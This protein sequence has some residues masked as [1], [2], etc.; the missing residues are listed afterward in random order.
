VQINYSFFRRITL[1]FLI[2]LSIN[3]QII[4]EKEQIPIIDRIKIQDQASPHGVPRVGLVLSGGGARGLA[5]VGVFKAL[6][7]H[8]IP[9]NLIVGTSMGSLVG[10]FYAA[11]YNARELEDIVKSIDWYNIFRDDTERENLFLGQKLEKDRFLAKIRFDNWQA[12]LP[13]SFTSGQKALSIISEKLYGAKY[14][15]IYDF[16]SLRVPFRVVATDLISGERVIISKGDLAEAIN[17]SATVPLLF[18][19]VVWGDMLLVDG[20]LRSNLSVDVA[21][22][23]GMDVIIV[24]DITSPLRKKNELNAPWEVADQVTTI[25]M[26]NQYEKQ[27]ILADIVVKPDLEDVGGTDFDKIDIMISA[28]EAAVDSVVDQI[29]AALRKKRSPLDTI[30]INY[31]DFSLV[32]SDHDGITVPLKLNAGKTDFITMSQIE[33]DVELLLQKGNYRRVSVLYDDSVLTY[34]AEKVEQISNIIIQGNSLFPD[35]ILYKKIS[36]ADS[37]LQT[38]DDVY[39]VLMILR[40]FYHRHGFVLMK[41]NNIEFN[42]NQMFVQI[43]EGQLDKIAIEGNMQTSKLVILRD[44]PLKEGAAYNA[45][46][47]ILGIENIYNTQL[48]DKVSVNIKREGADR[49]LVIKVKEKM[50][51]VLRLGGKVGTERGIQ[52]YYDLGNDN[53]FGTGSILSLA[54]RYGELDRRVGLNY[55]TDRI[56]ETY[57]TFSIQGYYDWK[58]NPYYRDLQEVGEYQEDRFGFKVLLGQQL[59]KLGQVSAE[60][61]IENAKAK[62]FSGEFDN[63]QNSELRTLTIRSITDKRDR[64]AFTTRGIY[65]VWYWEAGN[66]KIF[67]GQEKFTKALVNLEGYYTY[68]NIH[69]FHIKGVIGVGDKTLPFTEFFR[70]GGPKSFI[71][72]HQYELIGRQVIFGNL[73][74]RIKSPVDI[75]TDTY[76]GIKYDIGGIWE[77][78]DLVLT[79]EDFF[80]AYGVWLGIDTVLGPLQLSYGKSSFKSGIF[81]FSLGYDF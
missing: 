49:I 31:N 46:Q 52:G 16:D 10:G 78:P 45:N 22:S 50:Y 60:L 35:S 17:A 62:K 37:N 73:E 36:E 23:L 27:I 72:F 9:L 30:A 56:F 20:G 33:E 11:G 57:L 76:L 65:N 40:E 54:G 69:T 44:F 75:F 47:V 18:S 67:E 70:I 48:F 25:M 66:Q 13:T 24:V 4:F 28:G 64:I 15:M 43:D 63:P 21:K 74:Y 58:I 80:S 12:E 71:G 77:T 8:G 42:N 34:S 68:G 6:D 38:Y 1:C 32:T 19:P 51:S 41:Y 14:Q 81:Y 26:Q 29:K 39:N 59:R 79:S 53:L 7:K 61:R 55:R 5:H 3:A 2:P